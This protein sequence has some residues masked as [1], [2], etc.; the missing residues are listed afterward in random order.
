MAS[1]ISKI[2]IAKVYGKI[3]TDAVKID[4]ETKLRLKEDTP[5]MRVFGQATGFRIATSQY[6]DSAVFKGIFKGINLETGEEF[7][8]SE[9]CL[10]KILEAQLSGILQDSEGA[11]FGFDVHAVPAGNQFGYEYKVKALLPVED[12]PALTSLE[13]KINA[14]LALPAP[15]KA[16]PA[17]LAAPAKASNAAKGGKVKGKGKG[18]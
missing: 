11:E 12:A 16:N 2:T 6:G 15:A 5:L 18:K 4:G 17:A 14:R 3:K 7:T 10:P 9:C 1:P 8:A 13:E